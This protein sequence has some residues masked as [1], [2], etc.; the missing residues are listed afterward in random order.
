MNV[1]ADDVQMVVLNG[2]VIAPMVNYIHN[3]AIK[4]DTHFCQALCI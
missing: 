2:V 3:F 4:M 1:D